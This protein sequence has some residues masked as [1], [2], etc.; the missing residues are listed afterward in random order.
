MV[1]LF[2]ITSFALLATTIVV[3]HPGAAPMSGAEVARRSQFQ[4]ATRRSLGACQD[5]LA[6]RNKMDKSAARRAAPAD[7]LRKSAL[8]LEDVLNTDHHSNVTGLTVDSDPFSADASCVLTPELEQGP[9]YVKG[10]YVRKTISEDQPGLYSYVDLELIDVSTCEPLTGVYI[11]FWH[12]NSTGVYAGVIG[13]GNGDSSDL[14]NLVRQYSGRATHF[15]TVVHSDGTVFDNGT[16]T[17]SS[18]HHTGQIFFDQSLITAVELTSPYSSNTV[19]ITTVRNLP[20]SGYE[21]FALGVEPDDGSTGVDS[22]LEYVYLG[23]DVSDGLLLWGTIGVNMSASC[24]ISPAAT[25]TEDGGVLSGGSSGGS[26][27]GELPGVDD[28]SSLDV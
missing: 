27:G 11:D 20:K 21:M 17:A 9:F 19:A 10:E 25:L 13:S 28:G 12:C 26:P 24:T 8:T 18:E 5:T 3:G 15:H 2:S 1:Y 14:S 16:F 6:R 4:Q 7:E 22:V 23:D